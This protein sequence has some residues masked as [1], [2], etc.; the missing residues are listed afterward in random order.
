[1]KIIEN[2]TKTEQNLN[3]TNPQ[4]DGRE[5]PVPLGRRRRD[6]C[7]APVPLGR[8]QRRRFVVFNLSLFFRV[9]FNEFHRLP[10]DF[11]VFRWNKVKMKSVI[12]VTK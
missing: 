7:E 11:S 12:V 10:C 1:M 3:T 4:G 9:I 2:Q 6:G 5:A 8:R